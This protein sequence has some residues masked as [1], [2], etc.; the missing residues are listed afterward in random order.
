MI[1]RARCI[2]L[3]G[4]QYSRLIYITG[5][6]SSEEAAVDIAAFIVT[7]FETFTEFRGRPLHL[8]GESYAVNSCV[9]IQAWYSK[10]ILTSYEFKQGRYLPIFASKIYDQNDMLKKKGIVP[11]NLKSLAIGKPCHE[12]FSSC[13]WIS[14]VNF[15]REH[16]YKLVPVSLALYVSVKRYHWVWTNSML[17]S[18]HEVTCTNISV[19]PVQSTSM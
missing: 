8:T 5:Q 19:E 14:F 15:D 12:T 9:F 17:Y 18:Y 3:F 16:G 6:A 13:N 11:V 1:V 7:F 4:I 2:K 10:H